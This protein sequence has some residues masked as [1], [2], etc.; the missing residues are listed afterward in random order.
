MKCFV[1]YIEDFMFCFEGY[2]DFNY[3]NRILLD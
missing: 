3:Q 1:C 2:M